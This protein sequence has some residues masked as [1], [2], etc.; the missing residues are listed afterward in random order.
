MNA[1][2]LRAPWLD[3]IARAFVHSGIYAVGGAVRNTLMGL[4]FSDVDLCGK[5]RPEEVLRAC[6]GTGIYA[7][8][9]AANFGTVELHL[10]GHMAEYTTFRQDSYRG[11]HQPFAVQ[12]ADTVE[13]DA[14]RRDFSVNALYAPLND[15]DTII[16]PTS[17]LKRLQERVLHTVTED[18]DQVLKDDGLRIL[19][20]ARFQAELGLTPTEAVLQ[21]AAKYVQLLDDIAPERKRDELT[22]LLLSDSKYPTLARTVPPVSAGLG[23]LIRVGAWEKLFGDLEPMDCG[24]LDTAQEL[25]IGEKLALLY[26]RETPDALANRMIGLRFSKRLAADTA[27]ALAALQSMQAPQSKPA[28]ILRYGLPA[29]HRAARILRILSGDPDILRRVETLLA[30]LDSRQLPAD[31]RAL[32]INGSD[33]LVLCRQMNVPKARIGEALAALWRETVNGNVP[34]ERAALLALARKRWIDSQNME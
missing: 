34:N 16:D 2:P 33:L 7:R 29:T 12:F 23:T 32:A 17:G 20:A 24:V 14:L 15:P 22:K 19:R 13:E 9:R 26:H 3:A 10:D 18:P 5:L 1:S 31:V 28:D 4:P 8:L 21:S 6:V 30:Q 25:D 11:K 27:D